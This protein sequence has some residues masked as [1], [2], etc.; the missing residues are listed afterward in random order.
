MPRALDALRRHELT[1]LAGE[2]FLAEHAADIADGLI[3]DTARRPLLP[4]ERAAGHRPAELAAIVDELAAGTL[5]RLLADRRTFLDLVEPELRR[6]GPLSGLLWL[7][8]PAGGPFA[9]PVVA[10]LVERAERAHHA[11]LLAAWRAGVTTTEA[12]AARQGVTAAETTARPSA[13][14]AGLLRTLAR[15]MATVPLVELARRMSDAA[16]RAPNTPIRLAAGDLDPV[17]AALD[18]ARQAPTAGL[19]TDHARAPL[20]NAQGAGRVDAGDTLPPAVRW[21]ASE[22]LD[23]NTCSPCSL[24]DGR[25]FADEAE[26]RTYYPPD[27]GYHVRC[28]GGPR[29]RGTLVRIWNEEAPTVGAPRRPPSIDEPPPFTGPRRP[30]GPDLPP[31]PAAPAV[32][33]TREE[34]QAAERAARL[35]AR[36]EEARLAREAEAAELAEVEAD[37]YTAEQVAEARRDL[38]YYRARARDSAARL[39]ETLDASLSD[40]A[41]L[42]A[43]PPR[44]VVRRTGPGGRG[45]EV[46]R[47]NP[48]GTPYVG[49]EWDWYEGLSEAEKKRLLR[50]W[51]GGGSAAPDQLAAV[52]GIEDV[53]AAVAQWLDTNRRI[54]AAKA[55]ARG[56]MPSPHAY[57][58]LDPDELIP[59]SPF[60]ARTLFGNDP[61]E[62]VR[63]ILARYDD[64]A[65]ALAER[66][67]ADTAV[68]ELLGPR[69]WDM[70]EDA[71]VAE[72]DTIDAVYAANDVPLVD[73]DPELGR[74]RYAPDVE[75][76]LARLGELIPPQFQE[77]D[78]GY[79]D[80]HRAIIEWARRAGLTIERFAA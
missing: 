68:E 22:L 41:R 35:A 55:L 27:L 54:D 78:V 37:G 12:E 20:A 62:A 63:A 76:A 11:A 60:T 42:L 3:P 15:R 43:R 44:A 9:L 33:L 29:C 36:R 77:L 6:L 5:D 75:D 17:D 19:A 50:G 2:V 71:F 14:A 31:P 39:V 74:A 58:N 57:G 16:R 7:D 69:P 73:F 66:E 4:H 80:L 32:R 28:E 30:I 67:A 24:I 21:Y 26:A 49:G 25:E 13:P 64:E 46:R 47:Y 23:S 34:A 8:D 38:D 79:A 70:T 10:D 61:A 72:L 56:K 59:D 51:V 18:A 53:D 52:Y 65:V 40:D 45:V 1:V 48:D